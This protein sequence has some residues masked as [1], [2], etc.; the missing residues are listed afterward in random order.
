MTWTERGAKVEKYKREKERTANRKDERERGKEGIRTE[1][2]RD[3]EASWDREKRKRISTSKQERTL[4][5]KYV[6]RQREIT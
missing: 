4:V 6:H 5:H 3:I 2:G 1:G